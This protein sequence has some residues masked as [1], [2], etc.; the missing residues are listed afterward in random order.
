MRAPA[1][2]LLAL[3]AGADL[4]A[5]GRNASIA[6]HYFYWYRWPDRH[7]AQEG[8]PGREGHTRH[9]KAPETVSYESADWHRANFAAMASAGIQVALPVYWGAP[10]AYDLPH[11]AFARA[12]LAPMVA[13]LD[14]LG[15]DQGV[16]LGLFYD[17]ST[18]QNAV[19]NVEP[20]ADNADLTTDAGRALFCGTVVGYFERIPERHWARH[21]GGVLVV[22]YTAAYAARW[23]AGLADVLRAAFAKRFPGERVCLVADS[24]WGSIGQD[25]TTEWGA[26][27]AGP[28]LFPGVAQIGPGYDDSPV[29]D[30]RLPYRDREDGGFYAWSWQHVL[31]HRPSLVLLE[32][33]N[34]MHEGTEL[35]E[36]IEAGTQY[37]E[38]TR[39]WIGKLRRGV[40]AGADIVLRHPDPRP[41]PDKSWGA[42][43]AGLAV[44]SVDFG[45]EPIVRRGLRER[46]WEDGQVEVRDGA[47]RTTTAAA[48]KATYL[49]FQVSDHYAFDVEGDY[50]LEIAF[51]GKLDPRLEVQYDSAAP[52]APQRGA[53]RV[54]VALGRHREGGLTVARFAL[55]Q[56]NFA[57]R[58]NGECDLRIW[59]PGGAAAVARVA[60]KR[61]GR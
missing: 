44:A 1:L 49:Y 43:G 60:L 22:L 26:A 29:P 30:R 46:T 18:L 53:Y 6:A 24:S 58:Q 33:W 51:A 3:F 9:F 16:K 48:G 34:E 57:N 21:R 41:R 36:T 5:Q 50:A 42:E 54:A 56:A 20:R 55:P 28:K 45:A 2:L 8:A 59:T 32:T 23:D 11:L 39:Q 15:D 35:C 31:R 40:P 52:V 12:G 13:A 7:F 25:L 19:R 38:L 4:S 27:L 61:D 14:A 10:G 47:L 37:L 17:T